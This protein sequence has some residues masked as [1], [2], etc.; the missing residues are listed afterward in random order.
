MEVSEGNFS[1]EVLNSDKPVV[2]DYWAPWCGPCKMIAP[3][4]EKLSGEINN[5]KFAKVN[6]DENQDLAQQQGILGIP[7][8]IIYNNGEEVERVVGFQSEEQ[9]KSK[10]TR[11][12][13]S[14]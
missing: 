10:L 1:N 6:V 11:A 9:L 4:F 5:V 7:C 12:L 14:L 8:I 3:V 13:Q 2:V